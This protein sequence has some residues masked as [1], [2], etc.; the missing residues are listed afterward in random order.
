METMMTTERSLYKQPMEKIIKKFVYYRYNYEIIYLLFIY[1]YSL[2]N[3]HHTY[4]ISYVST[5]GFKTKEG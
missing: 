2:S 4:K 1:Y 3:L 5:F